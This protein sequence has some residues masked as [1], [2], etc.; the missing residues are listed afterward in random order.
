MATYAT[1]NQARSPSISASNP[2]GRALASQGCPHDSRNLPGRWR[3]LKSDQ[4]REKPARDLALA[5]KPGRS[6][7]TANRSSQHAFLRPGK[8]QGVVRQTHP[9]LVVVALVARAMPTG[10]HARR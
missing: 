2:K 8:H 3:G 10:R 1:A 9:R 6:K 5:H 7:Y 4:L